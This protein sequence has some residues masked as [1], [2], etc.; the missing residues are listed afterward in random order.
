MCNQ[1]FQW[2]LMI[3]FSSKAWHD[4]WIS[5]IL[6]LHISILLI[7][8]KLS[9]LPHLCNFKVDGFLF[10]W[11]TFSFLA[12]FSLSK[13]FFWYNR[14]DCVKEGINNLCCEF[15]EWALG[16]SFGSSTLHLPWIVECQSE[17]LSDR[18]SIMMMNDKIL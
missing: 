1:T 16:S 5:E 4:S 9:L 14:H 11:V 10:V 17:H 15:I 18:E 8:A 2:D 13:V 6:L 7:L 3:V 12:N